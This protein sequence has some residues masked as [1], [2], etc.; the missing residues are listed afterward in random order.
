MIYLI[1][2]KK[3]EVKTEEEADADGKGPYIFPSE[4][5][6]AVKEMRDKTKGD[7]GVPRHVLKLLGEDSLRIMTQLINNIHETGVC[8]KDFTEVTMTALKKEP[9]ATKCS[10]HCPVSLTAHTADSSRATTE[11]YKKN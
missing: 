9:E 5:E 2:H 3:L 8:C 11:D 4:G 6:K 7:N 1:N 10:D